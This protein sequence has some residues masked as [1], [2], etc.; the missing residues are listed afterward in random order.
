MCIATRW[1]INVECERTDA[2]VTEAIPGCT[3][4]PP[5]APPTSF[6][7]LGFLCPPEPLK[8]SALL[9]ETMA[10]RELIDAQFDRAVEIVQGLPKTGPVQTTYDEKLSM[11]RYGHSL[12]IIS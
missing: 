4:F 2:G 3:C 11:Y 5:V 7:Q 12:L 10:S 6:H 1:C 8:L 9:A